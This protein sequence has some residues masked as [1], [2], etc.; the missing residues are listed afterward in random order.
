MEERTYLLITKFLNREASPA[1]QLELEQ[2]LQQSEDN[3]AALRDM[4]ALWEDADA[5]LEQPGFDTQAA[6]DKVVA[7]TREEEKVPARQTTPFRKWMAI[8]VAAAAIAVIIVIYNRYSPTELLQVSAGEKAMAVELPDHSK[9]KL[10]PGSTLTYPEHFADN[11]RKVRLQGEAFFE[12]TH[13]PDQPFTI[14]AGTVDVQV[15]GT[16]FYV[17][18]AGQ[19]ATVTVTTGKVSMTS[20]EQHEKIILTPG[21]KGIFQ[22]N[23]LSSVADTNAL[24]YREGV[25]NL[26]GVSLADALAI[27]GKVKNASIAAPGLA[28]A[29]LA[30]QINIS[31]Q[32]QTTEQMLEE[33]CLITDTRWKKEKEQYLIYDR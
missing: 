4:K 31:F 15:L 2:W 5:L 20:R 19:L 32:H 26:T 10:Q 14:D 25:L 9:V 6:W 23:T 7:A 16:S 27:I 3:K 29:R 22:K 13:D 8:G 12:V 24:Y 18:T 17:T 11:G 21:H 1:E 33:L 28:D 30:Q